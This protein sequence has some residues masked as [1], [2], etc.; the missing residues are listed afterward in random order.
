[1]LESRL[2]SGG[3]MVVT[4]VLEGRG[5]GVGPASPSPTLGARVSVG[6]PLGLF[7]IRAICLYGDL[8]ARGFGHW[9]DFH[10]FII[11]VYDSDNY[12]VFFFFF[13]SFILF[14]FDD[15]FFSFPLPCDENTGC[16]Y[17]TGYGHGPLPWTVH[18]GS[19]RPHGEAAGSEGFIGL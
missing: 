8:D 18:G 11:F 1:V 14:F 16:H 19:R 12:H 15:F 17:A 13:G 6:R 2:D 10:R 3:G 5:G 7:R 9:D 4:G